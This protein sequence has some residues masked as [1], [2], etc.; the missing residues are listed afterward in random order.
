MVIRLLILFH[1]I[2]AIVDQ[3]SAQ[4]GSR[5]GPGY[6]GPDGR[7]VGWRDLNRVCGVPPETR[8]TAENASPQTPTAPIG[9]QPFFTPPVPQINSLPVTPNGT[10]F[11]GPMGVKDGD[12]LMFGRELRMWGIDAPEDSQQCFIQ[13][14]PW[15]CG[16]QSTSAL[17]NA[18]GQRTVTCVQRDYD[19][20]YNRPVVVCSV[21][22]ID[23][24]S[25]WQ[26]RNGW[27]IDYTRYS[28]GAYMSHQNEAVVAKRGIWQ[29]TFVRPWDF[30]ACRR[31]GGGS[32]CHL[33]P[34]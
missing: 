10:R 15:N 13:G 6:R 33:P 3:A 5:G 14:K 11:V 20:Q 2:F 21:G 32:Q 8:C 7:C 24:L 34:P 31:S 19:H 1:F 9:P 23:D 12:S 28:G 22:N 16:Q 29:G 26:A 27:A 30:R 4:C 18:V 25:G 17:R